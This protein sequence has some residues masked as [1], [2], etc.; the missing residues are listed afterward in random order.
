MRARAAERVE[1]ARPVASVQAD[2]PGAAVE[3]L[4]LV[5]A[6]GETDDPGSVEGLRIGLTIALHDRE[7]P[8]RRWR[9]GCP[10]DRLPAVDGLAGPQQGHRVRAQVHIDGPGRED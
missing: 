2:G 6:C 4:Q 7:E 5:R 1:Q 3:E 9:R 10:D 8:A